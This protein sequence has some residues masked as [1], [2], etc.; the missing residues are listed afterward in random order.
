MRNNGGIDCRKELPMWI[1]KGVRPRT[2]A[3]LRDL[4]IDTVDVKLFTP[5]GMVHMDPARPLPYWDRDDDASRF[6]RRAIDPLIAPA[7]PNTDSPRSVSI[8]IS[9][10]PQD[11]TRVARRAALPERSHPVRFKVMPQ[12]SGARKGGLR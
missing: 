2:G 12:G 1:G 5:V 3:K 6:L 4:V 9:E 8:E 7:G 10:Q 11:H